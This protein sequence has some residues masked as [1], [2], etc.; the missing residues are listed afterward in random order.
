MAFQN[1]VTRTMPPLVADE[2]TALGAQLDYHRRRSWPSCTGWTTS[3]RPSPWCRPGSACWS[4]LKHLTSDEVFWFGQVFGVT[5]PAWASRR[6]RTGGWSRATR[7]TGWSPPIWPRAS[8]A[9]LVAAAP[10]FDDR[11]TPVDGDDLRGIWST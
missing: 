9:R 6:V 4:L 2:P 3:R 8:G 11:V 10:S 5:R 7:S 1:P